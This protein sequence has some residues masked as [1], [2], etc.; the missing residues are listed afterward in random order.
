ML[1][2]TSN[3]SG[4][5]QDLS[6]FC[7]QF[8]LSNVI[9]NPTRVTLTSKS[10][11]DVILVSHADRFST[12][13]NLHLGISDHD[14]VYIV[15]R[16]KL[17][18]PKAKTI[19]FRST[20]NLDVPAF[21]SDLSVTPWD[22][23]YVFDHI[24]DVWPHWFNLYNQVLDKHAP[25]LH[26]RVRNNQLPW[27]DS[28][29]QREIRI[30]NRLYKKFRKN[31]TNSSWD[32]YRT[33]RNKVT[34]LKRNAVKHYCSEAASSTRF[35]R[36]FWKKMKPLL[37]SNKST[38]DN[39]ITIID[40]D[41]VVSDPSSALNDYFS[42]PTITQDILDLPEEDFNNHT[43]VSLIRS[44][45]F[46]LDFSFM[47][48]NIEY[49]T[50]L[51][52]TLDV[53]KSHGPD[54]LSPKLLKISTPALA[55]PL[56]KLLNFC[57][58]TSTWPKDWKLSNV[59]PAHK[60][61]DRTSKTNYRPISVLSI[62]PKMLE[63]IKFDQLY[64][65][66]CPTFSK[67]M[68]GFLRGHSC[69][70]ALI[71]ITDDWRL[72]LDQKKNVGVVA[73]DLSKAFDSIC[74]N[75]LLAKLGAY[76]VS[77][78]AIQLIRS[79]LQQRHQR[80]RCNN[81]FSDWLPVHCGVPQG[82]L[83]SPLL[84]NIFINDVNL[85]VNSSSLRLY[86]DDTTQYSADICPTVLE[87]TINQDLNKLSNWFTGNY[88]K[89]N[90]MKTQAM[91]LGK[92]KYSYDLSVCNKSIKIDDTLKILGVT[93]D[94]NLSFKP[95]V[96]VILSKVYAKIGA[97]RRL[98]RLVPHDVTTRLYKAYVLPHLEYCSPLLLGIGKVLS[99]KLESANHYGLRT[100][101]NL[102]TSTDYI[103]VLNTANMCTLEHRRYVQS[104]T[105]FFKSYK[106]QGPIYIANLFKPRLTHYN[107]RGNNLNVVQP[108][109]NNL[110][111]HKSFSYILSHLWNSLP[112]V[113]KTMD[114]VSHFKSQI[115]KMNLF[116]NCKCQQ[117]I[118]S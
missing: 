15:R 28:N 70:S 16:Q 33:Q 54:K 89:L 60:K 41:R 42:T 58:E 6:E 112:S 85:A 113:L 99:S 9:Q 81:V 84:F 34:S 55:A 116:S 27:I 56:T 22:S 31:P 76:G 74:H 67:N 93:L 26:T 1:L 50:K 91:I 5:S 77:G 103:S 107:L 39:T 11:I 79:F 95:H 45:A 69:C 109:Y 12:S 8:C 117:C 4:P 17:Q 29:T 21:L 25:I 86:A 57:I 102:G 96:D 78:P 47:P 37:P 48:V 101:M 52:T 40:N 38:R 62:I 36:D 13:G 53:K 23:S 92:T 82:S 115:N 66:F 10:L 61:D 24:D 14:L 46:N 75:L 87:Y 44:Q 73:I 64:D 90:T 35:A 18:K 97:L 68:S 108:S 94:R 106:R 59:Y 63:K 105:M 114:S 51:L 20:K 110:H 3:P 71:K 19:E 43:S 30:R 88:L 80:V 32:L 111:Y 49:V 83:L 104:L 65:A 7:N 72:A 2:G 100:L 98:K 118:S